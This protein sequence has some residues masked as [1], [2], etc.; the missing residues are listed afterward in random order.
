MNEAC[1]GHKKTLTG[2]IMWQ[3]RTCASFLR[4]PARTCNAAILCPGSVQGPTGDEYTEWREAD[5]EDEEQCTRPGPHLGQ[6]NQCRPTGSRLGASRT[7][8]FQAG[9]KATAAATIFLKN[10]IQKWNLP[11]Q[12]RTPPLTHSPPC[13]KGVLN[14]LRHTVCV[15]FRAKIGLGAPPTQGS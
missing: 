5:G 12:H 4:H 11:F 14:S 15:S 10:K 9:Y 1:W 13:S 7:T 6:C 8:R 2:S 3:L